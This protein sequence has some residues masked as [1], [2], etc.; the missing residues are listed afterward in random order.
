VYTFQ[1]HIVSPQLHVL[2]LIGK[3]N[4]IGLRLVGSIFI[5]ISTNICMDLCKVKTIVKDALSI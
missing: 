1:F 4:V 3:N 2:I 5:I